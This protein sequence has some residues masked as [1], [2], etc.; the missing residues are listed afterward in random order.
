M[1]QVFQV[2]TA[3][4]FDDRALMVVKALTETNG[5]FERG[6][7]EDGELVVEGWYSW[8]GLGEIRYQLEDRAVRRVNGLRLVEDPNGEY[9]S[10]WMSR[11]ATGD[12]ETKVVSG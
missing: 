7:Y 2:Q 8:P 1:I 4:A 12:W 11:R 9:Y 6:G 3:T 10:S 5:E